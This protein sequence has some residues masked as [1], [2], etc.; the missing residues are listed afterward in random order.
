MP[1]IAPPLRAAAGGI[2]ALALLAL[3]GC[4]APTP[5]ID[6]VPFADRS[7]DEF[8]PGDCFSVADI[9]NPGLAPADRVPCDTAHN[10][11]IVGLLPE[12]DGTPIPADGLEFDEQVFPKCF[13]FIEAS[14]SGALVELPLVPSYT[15]SL[16][17]DNV[18]I[19]GPVLCTLLTRNGDILE[20]SAFLVP[21][22][23]LLGDWTLLTELE[24]GTCFT[25]KAQNNIGL[26]AECESGTLMYLG[27]V[28][29]AQ[30]DEFPGTESLRRQ[31][32][33]GCAE[34]IPDDDRIASGTLSG[35]VPGDGDWRRGVRALTCDVEVI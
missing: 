33:E 25:L 3:T 6:L 23:E 34:L 11:E 27:F 22:R 28:E 5:T 31:R 13:E 4:G 17:A 30:D 18:T 8:Y 19:E 20:N 29:A 9:D 7:A 15:G 10:L 26:P 24:A 35:T 14:I 1:H 16:A 2:L 32:D 21:P 12:F